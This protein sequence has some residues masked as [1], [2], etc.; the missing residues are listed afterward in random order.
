M[1]LLFGDGNVAK[2][3]NAHIFIVESLSPS[4][5]TTNAAGTQLVFPLHRTKDRPPRG[6]TQLPL[7]SSRR[8]FCGERKKGG[9]E[10]P[11]GT[12]EGCAKKRE[13][14]CSTFFLRE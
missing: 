7:S 2:I 12:S 6:V 9:E 3:F 5:S 1:L 10:V 13:I 8:V 4:F 11:L 14:F